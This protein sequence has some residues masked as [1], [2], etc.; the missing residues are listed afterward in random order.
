[1][2]KIA[3]KLVVPDC[4]RIQASTSLSKSVTKNM[5][6]ASPRCATE[7]IATRGLPA[8]V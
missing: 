1:M 8:S 4:R 6:S 3:R 7:K 5:R 2:Y